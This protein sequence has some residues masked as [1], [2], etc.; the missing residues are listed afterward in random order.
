MLKVCFSKHPV[1]GIDTQYLE[2]TLEIEKSPVC[3]LYAHHPVHVLY[4][5][6]KTPQDVY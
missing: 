1:H 3:F 2:P 5:Y 6:L 4:M